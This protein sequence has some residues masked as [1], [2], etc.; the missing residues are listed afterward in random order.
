MLEGQCVDGDEESRGCVGYW[1][2]TPMVYA[3]CIVQGG[4][5]RLLGGNHGEHEHG[6]CI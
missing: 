4:V 3:E 1:F 6:S 5:S 2:T